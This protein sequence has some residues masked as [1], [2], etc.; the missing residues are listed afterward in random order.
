MEEEQVVSQVDD[1]VSQVDDE[2]INED[3][4]LD[5]GISLTGKKAA[6]LISR[7]SRVNN[8]NRQ[9]K[10]QLAAIGAELEKHRD[11]DKS[12]LERAASSLEKA[13]QRITELEQSMRKKSLEALAARHG[14]LDSDLVAYKVA[15]LGADVDQDDI[16]EVIKSLKEKSPFLFGVQGQQVAERSGAAQPSTVRNR[17]AEVESDLAKIE[18][19]LGNRLLF[20]NRKGQQTRDELIG[21]KH[22]LIRELNAME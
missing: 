8:E 16:E 18:E 20:A 21:K 17:R 14:A 22:R 3:S 9:L 11:K 7:K 19:A 10:K 12:E 2:S 5:E 6:E 15:Q 13:N 4:L 1:N